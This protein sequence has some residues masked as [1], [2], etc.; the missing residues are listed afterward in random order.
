[1]GRNWDLHENLF[2]IFMSLESHVVPEFFLEN[3]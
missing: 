1:M 3:S 2:Q